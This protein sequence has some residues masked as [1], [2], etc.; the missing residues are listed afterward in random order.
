M[1]TSQYKDLFISEGRELLS[2]LNKCLVSLEKQPKDKECLNEIF[3]QAHTLKG[4]AA[5]MSYDDITKLTHEME[6]VLDLL[7]R[8]SLEADTNT[9]NLLFQ[10]FDSLE[11]LVDGVAS[12]NEA[13]KKKENKIVSVLVSKLQKIREVYPQKREDLIKEKRSN[14][15]LEDSDRLEIAQ[16]YKEGYVTYRVT[17]SLKKDCVMKEARAFV[18]VKALEDLGQVIRAQFIYKQLESRKFGRHFGL[19]F[20]TKELS[21]IVKEKIIVVSGVDNIILKPLELDELGLDKIKSQ[22]TEQS[23]IDLLK[24]EENSAKEPTITKREA[25]MVRV[26]LDRLDSLMNLVGELVINKIRLNSIGVSLES[27]P[28]NEALTQLDRLTDELQRDI[29]ETRLVPMDY[30]FNRFPRIVRD[31]AIGENKEIDLIIEGADIGLDRTILDEINDPL[32]H[33]LRNSVNHGIEMPQRRIQLGKNPRGK[34]R[35]VARRERN[36]VIIEVSDDGQGIDPEEIRKTAIEKGI[37]SEAKAKE[38]NQEEIIMLIT[39]PGFSTTKT[40]NQISGRGVGMNLV[41]TKIESFGGVLTIQSQVSVG[42][43]FTLKLP[44]SMAI[45]Q[46]LLVKISSQIYAIPLVNI[47]ETIKIKNENIKTFEHHEVVTYRDE[48]LPLVRLKEKFGFI[49]ENINNESNKSESFIPVVIIEV[50]HKKI[51]LIIDGFIGQQEVV[52]KTLKGAI[53]NMAGLAGATILGD[54]KIAMII[55]VSSIV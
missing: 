47:L 33:L 10:S 43:K 29:M 4:M 28:L 17:I 24:L 6:S 35:L 18:V 3:R 5:S 9:V 32:I 46:A 41:K 31:L 53:K 48:V 44:L 22:Q 51:G 40:V 2:A 55:D 26:S 14:L 34:V 8:G 1:D 16:K 7:R 54:G 19:F 15:R 45:I 23:A 38:L 50:S 11:N 20:I 25:H 39:T 37:I 12:L 36:F 42:A 27:K 13:D 52:I 30:I 21:S 49:S